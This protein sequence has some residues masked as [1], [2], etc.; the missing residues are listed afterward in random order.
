MNNWQEI[1]YKFFLVNKGF[2]DTPALRKAFMSGFDLCKHINTFGY[3]GAFKPH[4]PPIKSDHGHKEV[5]SAN[6]YSYQLLDHLN[7][8]KS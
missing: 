6:P 4:N 3:P 8:C 7:N 2:G 5:I 1:N